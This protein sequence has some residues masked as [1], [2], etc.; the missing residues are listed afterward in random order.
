M[1]G[2]SA[3]PATITSASPKMISRAASP[4]A[5]APVEQAV[6]T[7]WF[8]PFSPW[9]IDTWP[10][11]RLMMLPGMKNGLMRRG[12]R[13]FRMSGVLGDAFDAA[14]AGADHDAGGAALVLGLRLPAG[15]LQRLVGGRDP[16]EDEVADLA[17]FLRLEHS[18]GIE[19]CRRC[20]RR[21][22]STCAILQARSS[23]SNSVT[24]RAG[25]LA[26]Q[27]FFPAVL[28]AHAERRDEAHAGDDDA[29]H[30]RCSRTRRTTARSDQAE[31]LS[32]YFTASPTVRMVSA[33]SSGNLD[34]E[35]FFERHDEF[36][37]VEAVRAQIVD[38]A[39]RF[40]HLVGVDAK[41]LDNDLLDAL[42]GVAHVG[43]LVLW[44]SVFVS[45]R[46]AANQAE[47][48]LLPATR[49]AGRVCA[50]TRRV[51]RR[52]TRKI[53]GVQGEKRPVAA[54][55][56]WPAS[57]HRH[58]AIHMN[59]L[60]GHIAGLVGGEIGDRRGDLGAGSHALGRDRAP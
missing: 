18:L 20:R 40:G 26:G 35:F 45:G 21:A 27:Q 57:D 50:R 29:S 17:Q 36:D 55:P 33:A 51:A 54:L 42:C 19:A 15:I 39:R 59:G 24:R 7:A 16:V 13:S 37:R 10:E 46:N 34:A 5:C 56:D 4:I 9:R 23:T 14:D 28:D 48:W 22:E 60:A 44:L 2:A 31:A 43:I 8:G 30:R 49:P 6:T 58:A 11:T 1:I 3:P 47:R 12:P 52:I 41:M 38:E 25:A 32:M 53:A